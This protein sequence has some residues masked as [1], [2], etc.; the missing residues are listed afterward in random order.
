MRGARAALDAKALEVE[1]RERAA[2]RVDR[3]ERAEDGADAALIDGG[4]D[5]GGVGAVECRVARR[6][7]AHPEDKMGRRREDKGL[8]IV[9]DGLMGEQEEG[10]REQHGR[11]RHARFEDRTCAEDAAQR[12]AG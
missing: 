11:R 6:A 3:P 7:D 10:T 1:G 12:E 4:G 8:E 2:H 9:G 5:R